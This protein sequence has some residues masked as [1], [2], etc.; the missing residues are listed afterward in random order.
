MKSTKVTAADF[1]ALE[2]AIAK[3]NEGAKRM[4]AEAAAKNAANVKTYAAARR[5]EVADLF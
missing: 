5:A 2:A 1:A 3:S 4:A